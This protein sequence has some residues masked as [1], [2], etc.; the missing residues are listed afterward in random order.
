MKNLILAL[1]LVCLFINVSAQDS[2]KKVNSPSD[3]SNHDSAD[4]ERSMM[5]PEEQASFQGGDVGKFRE[6]VQHNVT[7]PVGF[8]KSKI[9]GKDILVVLFAVNCKGYVE[10]IKVL[11]GVDPV[12]DIEVMRCLSSS[13]KWEPG[14]QDGKKIKQFFAIPVDFQ[15][16]DVK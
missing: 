11:R 14:K 5:L 15:K 7:Y 9:K 12:L 4:C 6:W 1:Y 13:P 3:V 16:I 10:D 2:I 8:D